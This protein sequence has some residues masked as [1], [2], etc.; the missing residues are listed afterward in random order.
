MPDEIRPS[1]PYTT[2]VSISPWNEN[3]NRFNNSIPNVEA[4][5]FVDE[6]GKQRTDEKG[7]LFLKLKTYQGGF[8]ATPRS[9]IT[10]PDGA[11]FIVFANIG[12]CPD[13]STLVSVFT[14]TVSTS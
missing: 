11:L 10:F 3:G 9:E 4:Y 7:N 1:L 5:W 2:T 12:K 13:C 14:K 8:A 6:D